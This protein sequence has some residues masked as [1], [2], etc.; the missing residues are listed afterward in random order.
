MYVAKSYIGN[1]YVPGEVIGDDVSRETLKWLLESGAVIEMPDTQPTVAGRR[2]AAEA[3]EPDETKT[4][5][6]DRAE[7]REPDGAEAEEPDGINEA[8]LEEE[9]VEVP[10]I[11]VTS[12]I[13]VEEQ[14]KPAGTKRAG[15]GKTTGKGK[16]K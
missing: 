3:H 9:E 16:A 13:V 12:G 4:E 15:K 1:M 6:Q 10:E 7:A 14:E 2:G 5:E 11:D 8:E